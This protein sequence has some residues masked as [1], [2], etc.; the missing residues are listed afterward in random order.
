[1]PKK[2]LAQWF[3]PKYRIDQSSKIIPVQD[4]KLEKEKE[5]SDLNQKKL[6]FEEDPPEYHKFNEESYVNMRSIKKNPQQ[7]TY[8]QSNIEED[9]IGFKKAEEENEKDPLTQNILDEVKIQETL[10]K[11]VFNS[12]EL[13]HLKIAINE[14]ILGKLKSKPFKTYILNSYARILEEILSFIPFVLDQQINRLREYHPSLSNEIMEKDNLLEEF[15]QRINNIY[16]NLNN[17]IKEPKK[18]IIKDF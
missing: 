10:E 17:F 6:N 18:K 15:G 4:K 7:D 14:L 1:M 3:D 13:N 5:N 11:I 8:F 9:L 12:E 2:N 16:L